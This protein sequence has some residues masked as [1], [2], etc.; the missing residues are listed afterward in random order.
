VKSI[1]FST[2]KR[3]NNTTDVVLR[4]LELINKKERAS[5]RIGKFFT[6]TVCTY[7]KYMDGR[8]KSLY[9]NRSTG[10]LA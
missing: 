2:I 5:E 8:G 6:F 4:A 9:K 1:V 3:I 7:A 10:S